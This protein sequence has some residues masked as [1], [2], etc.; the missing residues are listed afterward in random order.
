MTGATPRR[1]LPE[2]RQQGGRREVLLVVRVVADACGQVRG[3][4]LRGQR[5]WSGVLLGVRHQDVGSRW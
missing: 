1:Q 4:R 5:T 3:V 2:L